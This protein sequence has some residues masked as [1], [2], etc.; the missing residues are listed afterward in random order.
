MRRKSKDEDERLVEN[1][2]FFLQGK[3]PIKWK[4]GD[5]KLKNI[6]IFLYHFNGENFRKIE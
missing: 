1:I 4:K 6:R 5:K 2:I 3:Y